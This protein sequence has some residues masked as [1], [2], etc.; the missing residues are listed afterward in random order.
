MQPQSTYTPSAGPADAG[1]P[2]GAVVP[3]A[4]RDDFSTWSV[5]N[6]MKLYYSALQPLTEPLQRR[7]ARHQSTDWSSDVCSS[8]LI[9]L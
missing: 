2:V 3:A 8:D 7:N 5:Q 6:L 9:E 1:S 4:D